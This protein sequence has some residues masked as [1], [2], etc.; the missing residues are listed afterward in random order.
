MPPVFIIK[1]VDSGIYVEGPEDFQAHFEFSGDWATSTTQTAYIQKDINRAC[2]LVEETYPGKGFTE[3]HIDLYT[4]AKIARGISG[5]FEYKDYI[6]AS[7]DALMA[8]T[9]TDNPNRR[10]GL[11]PYLY[12]ILVKVEGCRYPNTR[13]MRILGRMTAIVNQAVRNMEKEC[14]QMLWED[15]EPT[16]PFEFVQPIT[17]RKESEWP[18]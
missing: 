10:Y 12:G 6:R 13:M 15:T 4:T 1:V 16:P 18:K 7:P 8:I 11:A 9:D 2:T 3:E 17:V 14:R 5:S